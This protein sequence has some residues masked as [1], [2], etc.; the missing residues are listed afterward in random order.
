MGRFEERKGK[1]KNHMLQ[2]QKVYLRKKN[3]S[4]QP[5]RELPEHLWVTSWFP[6]SAKTS[7]CR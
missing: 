4:T 5:G 7:L 2:S 3:L 6:D 1:G